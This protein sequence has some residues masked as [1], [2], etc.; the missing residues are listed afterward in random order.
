MKKLAS[1]LLT[2]A[3]LAATAGCGTPPA[4]G[5]GT[6][7]EAADT[8]LLWAAL[9]GVYTTDDGTF[10]QF[11]SD[12]GTLSYSTGL[13]NSGFGMVGTPAAA[14]KTGE[15]AYKL[16]VD[17]AAREESA[18][19]SGWDAFSADIELQCHLDADPKTIEATDVTRNDSVRTFTYAGATLADVAGPAAGGT[20][21]MGIDEAWSKFAGIWY[22]NDNGILRFAFFTV[23]N[24]APTFTRGTLYSGDIAGGAVSSFE[25][26]ADEKTIRFTVYIPAIVSEEMSRDEMTLSV[27]VE[28]A[29]F[30]NGIL[31]ISD[32]SGSGMPDYTYVCADF[33]EFAQIDMND[34]L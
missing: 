23:E 1:V 14:E 29:D 33:N 18:E 26:A 8:A 3:L 24:G 32:I 34:L 2:L 21:A 17:F 31:R 5:G 30:D 16:T 15:G 22:H 9:N 20:A 11:S 13:L 7:G 6:S 27:A 28:Y 25:D 19:D 4:T 10:I 12:S